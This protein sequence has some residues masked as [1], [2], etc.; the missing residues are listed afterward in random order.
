MQ[1]LFGGSPEL[2]LAVLTELQDD[3][4]AWQTH[5]DYID[6]PNAPWLAGQGLGADARAGAALTGFTSLVTRLEG[7]IARGETTLDAITT[8]LRDFHASVLNL[9]ANTASQEVAPKAP[10]GGDKGGMKAYREAKVAYDKRQ[11]DAANVLANPGHYQAV[12]VEHLVPGTTPKKEAARRIELRAIGA[13]T[14]PQRLKNDL[15]YIYAVLE[16]A[17]ATVDSRMSARRDARA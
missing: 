2:L 9:W 1:T 17:R 3:I 16:R 6:A 10:G 14:D 4:G 5:F 13:Q 11:K 8:R 7:E 12:N 15:Q